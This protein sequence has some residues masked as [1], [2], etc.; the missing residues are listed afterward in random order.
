MNC[1]VDLR[2][3][4]VLD[5]EWV[6]TVVVENVGQ[7]WLDFSNDFVFVYIGNI[8]DTVQLGLRMEWLREIEVLNRQKCQ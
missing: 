4:K 1:S 6:Y 8:K 7:V 3:M 2:T 5:V